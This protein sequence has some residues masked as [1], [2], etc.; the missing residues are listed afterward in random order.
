[1]RTSTVT[2]I[3]FLS[4]NPSDTAALQLD[5]ELRQIGRRIRRAEYRKLFDIKVAPGLRAI[6]LPYE[7]MDAR[8][9]VVHF[10]GHGSMTGEL[11]FLN[12]ADRSRR[13]IPPATLSRVF[14][15]LKDK[16]CCVVLNACYSEV[17]AQAIVEWIPCVVG[18]SRA[19]P[20]A[21][22]IAFAAGFY[23]ALAF[24]RTVAEAFELGLSQIELSADAPANSSD[25]PK[26][27]VRN[28]EDATKIRL[29]L[30]PEEVAVPAA[31]VV[32]SATS[33]EQS[34]P[35]R[36]TSSFAAS[37]IRHSSNKRRFPEGYFRRIGTM[38]LHIDGGTALPLIEAWAQRFNEREIPTKITR[39]SRFSRGPQ[40]DEL[41]D[42]YEIHTPGVNQES[43]EYF[44]TSLLDDDKHDIATLVEETL[45]EIE[46]IK[47]I[48]VEL[49]RVVA[50]VSDD[51]EGSDS[52]HLKGL[53]GAV[54][55]DTR[56][57]SFRVEIHYM[58]DI[59]KGAD[60]KR[61][62]LS[63]GAIVKICNDNGIDIGGWFLFER[64]D[65]WAYR[66]NSFA[67]KI[68]EREE[69]NAK[70]LRLQR[71]LVE[72]SGRAPS[73]VRVK[74]VVEESVGIWKTPVTRLGPFKTVPELADWED[75]T[76]K[77]AVD[78]SLRAFWVV[79]PN[80]LGDK[81][82][83]IQR[84]MVQNLATGVKYTYF[85]RSFADLKRWQKFRSDLKRKQE[86]IQRAVDK[87][88][89]AVL[90]HVL[91]HDQPELQE[92]FI[93]NPSTDLREAYKLIRGTNGEVTSGLPMSP[94]KTRDLVNKLEP[95]ERE[96]KSRRW[97]WL[98]INRD[99]RQFN[100]YVIITD[101]E[102]T[103]LGTAEERRLRE[104]DLIIADEVSKHGGEVTKSLF[105]GYVIIFDDE[106]EDRG[107]RLQQVVK[108]ADRIINLAIGANLP[109][110]RILVDF[111][112]AR[113][114]TRAHGYDTISAAI[115]RGRFLLDRT[116]WNCVT[117]SDRVKNRWETLCGSDRR[118]S[119]MSSELDGYWQ[120]TRPQ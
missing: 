120:L 56:K 106:R 49:E 36:D 107:G 101:L 53:Q 80:F 114:V 77:A 47:G 16:I 32:A 50:V 30:S 57:T 13:A 88:M 52:S 10:S 90:L 1:M 51:A 86:H 119:F 104:Y 84:T 31:G 3:L 34:T 93:R 12:E 7:L 14:K 25:I 45:A 97:T 85:L 67:L 73:D 68:P 43:L 96:A 98:P 21:S 27:L 100:A 61:E 44:T 111:D 48:V 70:R 6:D 2:K 117:V 15:Q 58:V 87:S 55:F 46:N 72:A 28:G 112:S 33:Q 95:L 109:Q 29:V 118:I 76:R 19:V 8:P 41:K 37:A 54:R 60:D 9:E 38:H 115:A 81:H 74:V 83:E 66:S 35:D 62:P 4:A 59:S 103:E 82:E 39:V 40:R 91:D 116:V 64:S 105:D 18:M 26:L 17:Q 99:G 92:Y 20:D 75:G 89:S 11:V 23:E 22:A 5:E 113:R 71:K 79:T 24:G 42:T 102:D 94:E 63:L 78:P 108:C 110:Q 69:L 65:I